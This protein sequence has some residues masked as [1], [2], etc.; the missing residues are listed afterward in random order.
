MEL[1]AAP[2]ASFRRAEVC[3]SVHWAASSSSNIAGVDRLVRFRGGAADATLI[4]TSREGAIEDKVVVSFA[5]RSRF[6]RIDMMN[7]LAA[8]SFVV[9]C[10]G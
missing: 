8:F 7:V 6:P 4:S 10:V 5:E 9:R 2:A 3:F 1:R